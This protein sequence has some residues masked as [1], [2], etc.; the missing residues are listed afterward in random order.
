MINTNG[1]AHFD[2]AT[3]PELA[4]AMTN[5]NAAQ[6]VRLSFGPEPKISNERGIC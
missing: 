2:P 1:A 6:N 4:D 5:L 3:S